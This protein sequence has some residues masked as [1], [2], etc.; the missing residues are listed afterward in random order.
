MTI[1]I[2][3]QRKRK[4]FAFLKTKIKNGEEDPVERWITTLND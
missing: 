3:V 2:P 1:F 4:L